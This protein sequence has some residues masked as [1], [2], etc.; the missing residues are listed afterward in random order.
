MINKLLIKYKGLPAQVRASVWFL[1]CS[2][3]QRG[4]SFITTPIF[5]R[6]LSSAEYGRYNVFNSW[7]GIISIIV[8]LNLSAGV[9]TSGL[10]KFEKDKKVFTSSLQGLTLILITF[11]TVIYLVFQSFWN[12]LFSLTTTQMLLML[13]IIW[14]SKVF[15]FWAIEQKVNL[16]YKML[17]LITFFVTI[18]TP[19]LGVILVY[20]AEDKVTARILSF[21]IINLIA[22]TWMFVVQMLRG[23][24]IY[25]A[26]FWKY[27][28]AFNIPLIPHYLSMTVLNS[29]DR[30]MIQNMVGD[31]EAGI[32][33]LAYSLS[34]IMT[35]FNSA[36]M[37]TIEPWLYKKIKENQIK[38]I[39]RVAYPVFMLVAILNILL[40]AFAPEVIKIFAPV[41]YYEAIYV[42]PPVAMSVFFMF[43][44]TFF[45]VFEFY[46]A[47]TKQVAVA[48]SAGALLNLGL[49]FV[50]IRMF[51]YIAAAYTTLICYIVFSLVH[52]YYM[53]Q[54]CKEKYNGEMPY[55]N[56]F[57]LSITFV[58]MLIGFVLLLTYNY[59]IVRYGGIIVFVCIGIIERKKYEI[60]MKLV[61]IRK[62]EDL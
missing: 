36:L 47:R 46:Y 50:F 42:I 17:I 28:L 55:D 25:S 62:G 48:T 4:I 14:T 16:Q 52:Y 32:Y 61:S 18:F 60:V 45:A 31:S 5:T 2:F 57:F 33:S 26:E 30:I 49:N 44:Y 29:A 3:L 43:S 11:W 37:Q 38:G 54:I 53:S 9:Y 15:E 6:L 35:L 1:I 27:A 58:F 22:Y 23:E 19:L 21:V 10:V 59:P 8:T 40:I 7:M 56:R 51:G 13:V 41:E 34:M 20:Y 24:K 12:R 39:S